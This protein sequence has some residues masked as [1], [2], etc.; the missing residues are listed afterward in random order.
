MYVCT[1]NI[2]PSENQS[3]HSLSPWHTHNAHPG[4]LTTPTLAHSQRGDAALPVDAQS[5][6]G[7]EHPLL[8]L[9]VAR[10]KRGRGGLAGQTMARGR[11]QHPLRLCVARRRVVVLE[12][13]L[14]IRA[15]TPPEH[16]RA[17]AAAAGQH[18]ERGADECQHPRG[19][20]RGGG[21]AEALALAARLR[22]GVVAALHHET[23]ARAELRGGGARTCGGVG[24]VLY[25]PEPEPDPQPQP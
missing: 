4:T 8:R 10:G 16:E 1:C 23:G 21:V 6:A 25:Q 22:L 20:V 12:D 7:P 17:T 3:I 13:E 18:A 19:G 2:Y 5:A 15:S 14:S 11:V 9:A 24:G